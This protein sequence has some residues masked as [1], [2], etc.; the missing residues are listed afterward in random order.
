[1]HA[2][3]RGF[4]QTEGL[5]PPWRRQEPL[6]TNSDPRRSVYDRSEVKTEIYF[7]T[8]FLTFEGPPKL[9]NSLFVLRQC[10]LRVRVQWL[11][12]I[13]LEPSTGLYDRANHLLDTHRDVV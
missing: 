1:M 8:L 5:L 10:A 13:S 7:L 2:D 6:Q 11:V 3:H 4:G 9:R 12:H